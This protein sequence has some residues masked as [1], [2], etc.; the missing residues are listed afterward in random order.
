MPCLMRLASLPMPSFG[1]RAATISR[2][3]SF[4][5]SNMSFTSRS[6]DCEKRRKLVSTSMSCA[7]TRS[8][9][10]ER[11]T[12]PSSTWRT[13]SVSPIS[14]TAMSFPWNLKEEVRAATLRPSIE[15]SA[16]SSPSAMPSPRYCWSCPA[17]RSTKG[18]TAI[19]SG[20]LSSVVDTGPRAEG[21]GG[22]VASLGIGGT[23][24]TPSAVMS[25]PQADGHAAPC[26]SDPARRP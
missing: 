2:A 18:S 23:G 16:L 21:W 3:I 22:G 14:F 17:L 15:A 25:K 4:R 12:L 7:V 8:F 26:A 9:C 6:E 24:C 13:C 11:R 10:P 5:M 19:D 20:A 1:I